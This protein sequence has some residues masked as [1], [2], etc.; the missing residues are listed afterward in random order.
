MPGTSQSLN[1]AGGFAFAVDDWTR[2]DRFL[3]LGSEGG[4]YYASE[5]RLTLQNV[6]AVRRCLEADGPR[7][8]TRIVTIS[9]E[10]RALKNDPAIFALAMAAGAGSAATRA[11]ALAALPRVCRT[12]TH[13][14]QFAEG[15]GAMR[16]WGRA[17]R[18]AVGDWYTEKT[19][20]ELAHQLSKYQKRGGW[21][22]QDLLRMCH[23]KASEPSNTALRWAVGKGIE[24]N[25]MDASS[26]LAPIVGFEAIKRAATSAEVIRLIHEYGLPRECVPT[27]WL[28]EAGVWEALLE[29]MPLGAL[30]R[31]LATMTRV[32]LLTPGSAAAGRVV[33]ALADTERLRRSRLHPIAL[34]AALRT[35]GSGRGIL[36]RGYWFPVSQIV[37][38]LDEAF[39]AA[40]RIPEPT[41]K[42]WL[43][44]L[45]VSGSM[46][47]GEVAGIPGLTPRDAATAMALV[48]AATEVEHH[49]I[50][51]TGRGFSSPPSDRPRAE[52]WSQ[53]PNARVGVETLPIGP[54]QRLDDAIQIVSDLPM[55]P[56]DCSLP[57]LY[58]LELRIPVDVFVVYTDSE[59]WHG[60]I[61]PIQALH[62][63]RNRMGIA[64]KLIVVAMVS[65]GFSIA[66]PDDAG[67]MDVVGF[68]MAVP[69]LISHF[70]VADARN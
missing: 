33:L 28:T 48:T 57:M 55:G 13:L 9:D 11:L 6:E 60:A 10:G 40:F 14:F 27:R 59:T 56:T 31:N 35:Y 25:A 16:G 23:V 54:G 12:G 22:H 20:R 24:S 62:R 49:L 53:F 67:M 4:S 3:V 19:P 65:S 5:R 1:N 68:D 21:S 44:A 26:P 39:Y 69:Q 61:H 58:A 66:D 15:I 42:R 43:L 51:F 29:T 8:V 30:V 17:L 34:L 36:G 47:H 45:D 50:G 2:L 32:G 37:D 38:A 41:N 52:G 46:A 64:A 63:Y 70:A 18:R 7:A